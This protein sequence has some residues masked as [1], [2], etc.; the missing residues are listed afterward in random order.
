VALALLFSLLA[1]KTEWPT[2]GTY[3]VL[4]LLN[5]GA[6]SKAGPGLF[7]LAIFVLIYFH[8]NFFCCLGFLYLIYRLFVR[9]HGDQRKDDQATGA[10]CC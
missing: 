2:P 6:V 1:I 3:L 9:S 4:W 5:P 8:T 7:H 10:E